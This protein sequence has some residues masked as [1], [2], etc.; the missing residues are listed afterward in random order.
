MQV[1]GMVHVNV[2]CRD[3]ARSRAF[4]EMLGFR[5]VY[6]YG[7]PPFYGQVRRDNARLN[8]RMVCEPVFVGD[9]AAMPQAVMDF[10]RDGDVVMCMG[11]GSIG[12]V[13]AKL[14]EAAR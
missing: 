3:Y 12:G 8:L 2:N 10:A 5:V 4:Y 13:P 1:V 9:I 6:L 11:A 14:A 7:E